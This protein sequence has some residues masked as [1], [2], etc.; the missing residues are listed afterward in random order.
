MRPQAD[1]S[2]LETAPRPARAVLWRTAEI[3][4]WIVF[5]PITGLLSG[6]ALRRLR[7][8]QPGWAAMYLVANLLILASIPLVTAL[9][10]ARS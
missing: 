9:I 7:N 8:N 1:A 6:L 3:A 4:P 5:G 10:A 2:D